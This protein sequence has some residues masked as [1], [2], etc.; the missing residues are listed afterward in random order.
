MHKKVVRIRLLHRCG[1]PRRA[2][3]K[4]SL[5]A[6]DETFRV[7]GVIMAV[8]IIPSGPPARP[9]RAKGAAAQ[10][11]A[12]LIA[13]GV[14]ATALLLILLD[15]TDGQAM[16]IDVDDALRALQVRLFASG[17]AGWYD[18]ALPF[19]RLPEI[20][21]S[22]WSRLVD[23]PY[24][25]ITW[26]AT[27][28][29]GFEP[30]LALSF[31]GWPL[32][33]LGAYALLCG[34]ICHRFRVPGISGGRPLA[35]LASVM[36]L[37]MVGAICE[38]A[39]GRI[40]HHNWQLLAMLALV[41]GLARF[42]AAGGLLVGSAA[43]LSLLVGL[44]CLPLVVVANGG[45]ALAYVCG[46]PGAGRMLA[47]AAAGLGIVALAGG[48]A[49]DG[50]AALTVPRCDVLSVSYLLPLALMAA[51]VGAGVPLLA[52]HGGWVRG[53]GARVALILGTAT[54]G[55]AVFAFSFPACLAGP[56]GA[57]DPVAR[58]LWL[59]R[60][61]QEHGLWFFYGR[62]D[63]ALAALLVLPMLVGAAA[64]IP[65]IVVWKARPGLAIGVAVGLA[66]LVLSLAMMRYERFPAAILPLFLPF[67]LERLTG[68]A[69]GRQR[70]GAA[71]LMLAALA[72][73]LA[74]AFVLRATDRPID[75][76]DLMAASHC[77]AGDFS[78]LDRAAPG[79]IL[80]PEG[81]ALPIAS[82][83]F[84]RH[85]VGAIP[86]H[87]ADHGM[88]IAFTAFLTDQPA[89]R[90]HALKDFDYVAVCR[91]PP[92]M[93]EGLTGLW[94]MLARGET[95]DGLRPIEPETQGAFRLLSVT[96][97]SEAGAE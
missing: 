7:N 58:S 78:V 24:A 97:D 47:C 62:G 3:A 17:A 42:D 27:P 16:A 61:A 88:A 67:A 96:H 22:P 28:L 43:A 36:T 9:V 81:L 66:A 71:F 44:E 79:R 70:R 82:R 8:A 40:D 93:I 2:G 73:F 46:R 51:L 15:L 69:T 32:V 31:R 60:V 87:R 1:E 52:D 89:V 76:A 85:S 59:A 72:A 53:W 30:A 18:R 33:M 13:L 54:L 65:A 4:T 45:L 83:S 50:P 19:V 11:R 20:Y 29:L 21:V 94:A 25:L 74:P 41:L 77:P 92:A 91:V 23:L 26:L 6:A 95:P 49:L 38:F 34:A 68:D 90:R 57:L 37:A 75:T 86:F 48:L 84:G 64:A 55:G 12:A 14:F 80:A 39:P 56:Y 63:Y 35:L 5:S 10:R